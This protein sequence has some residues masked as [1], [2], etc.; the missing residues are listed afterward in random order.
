MKIY[1]IIAYPLNC[2]GHSLESK[3]LKNYIN[4][5]DAIKY[6]TN[7]EN[8]WHEHTDNHNCISPCWYDYKEYLTIKE[9]EV[10]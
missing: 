5:D 1:Q 9:I 3:V 10:E 4:Y 6:K 2:E 7:W 8:L